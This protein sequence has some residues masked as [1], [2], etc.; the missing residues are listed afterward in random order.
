MLIINP[1][2]LKRRPP[3][4]IFKQQPTSSSLGM[5]KASVEGSGSQDIH[6]SSSSSN[7]STISHIP[8]GHDSRQNPVSTFNSTNSTNFSASSMQ[9]FQKTYPSKMFDTQSLNSGRNTN[10]I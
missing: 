5:G 6:S 7:P 4:I 10:F 3:N 2:N 1:L 8:N 9:A